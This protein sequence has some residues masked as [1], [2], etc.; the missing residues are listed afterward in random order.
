[1][2]NFKHKHWLN[3]RQKLKISSFNFRRL[4]YCLAVA[5]GNAV[6][7]SPIRLVILQLDNAFVVL[8]AQKSTIFTNPFHLTGFAVIKIS[9]LR[10]IPIV[11]VTV[12][13][14]LNG[15]PLNFYVLS[16][17]LTNSFINVGLFPIDQKLIRHLA[18]DSNVHLGTD[19]F[20]VWQDG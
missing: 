14:H 7:T 9:S 17:Q 4:V 10:P 13:I 2:L 19:R 20:H 12:H 18:L 8:M 5:F 15:N 6:A 3:R 16:G 11:R 1:M